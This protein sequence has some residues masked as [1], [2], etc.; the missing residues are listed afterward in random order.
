MLNA[1]ICCHHHFMVHLCRK[2]K[3]GTNPVN[4][5]LKTF[6]QKSKT[7]VQR[8]FGG[9]F[10][11]KFSGVLF[12]FALA[13]CGYNWG[14]G[15]RS[16]PGGHQ[17]VFV[18]MFK[19]ST[20]ELGAEFSFTQALNRELERSG[21]ITLSPK[22]QAEV[23]ITGHIID[24]TNLDS[25]SQP[26][27]FQID[28]NTRQATPYRAP[29]FTVYKIRMTVNLKATG[30]HDKKVLWQSLV[31]GEK[32]YRGSQLSQQGIRSS[33]VLYNE[34]RRKQTVKWIANDM[35]REAFDRL[36]ENF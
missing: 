28:Y 12:F 25:G 36:T 17:R 6:P 29:L 1:T 4:L 13:G 31:H 30:A 5:P 23:I 14:P 34:S 20:H 35:M 16:L 24:V 10:T 2:K 22:Q 32:S 33:N 8:F 7:E 15:S 18:E 19:N 9:F 27:F 21:F 11:I 3:V 26:T